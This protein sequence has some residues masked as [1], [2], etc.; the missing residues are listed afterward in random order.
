MICNFLYYTPLKSDS[1]MDCFIV[2]QS[3]PFEA[4]YLPN[5]WYISCF[6]KPLNLFILFSTN[7]FACSKSLEIRNLKLEIVSS[8]IPFCFNSIFIK[9]KL[10]GFNIKRDSIHHFAN[11]S[12]FINFFS[13]S[14]AIVFSIISG[15]A[16]LLFSLSLSSFSLRGRYDKNLKEEL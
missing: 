2:S 16:F 9:R 12:S 13:L 3:K 14:L 4:R 6:G 8:G 11:S 1:S 7:F 10:R 5:F 15:E